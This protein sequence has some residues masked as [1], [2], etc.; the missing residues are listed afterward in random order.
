MAR[1]PHMARQD[2]VPASPLHFSERRSSVHSCSPLLERIPGRGRRDRQIGDQRVA[3]Q[4]FANHA[5]HHHGHH[6][7]RVEPAAVVVPGE[8][9]RDPSNCSPG[10][11]GSTPEPGSV[12]LLVALQS[13]ATE[14]RRLRNTVL[15]FDLF[16]NRGLISCPYERPRESRQ[17]AAAGRCPVRVEIA[18]CAGIRGAQEWTRDSSAGCPPRSDRNARLFTLVFRQS[19]IPAE[20]RASFVIF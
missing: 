15:R 1:N 8:L 9:G 4:V 6:R 13:R 17:W 2:E 16:A 11:I 19:T 18:C 3:G 7:L 5:S 12:L 20:L 14:G 10:S